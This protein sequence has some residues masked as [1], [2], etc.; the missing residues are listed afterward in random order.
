MIR[1]CYTFCE[2]PSWCEVEDVI[3]PRHRKLR[4]KIS[5]TSRTLVVLAMGLG[6][7][8]VGCRL[9]GTLSDTLWL[10]VV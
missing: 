6:F 4:D 10:E 1:T 2:H 3:D 7:L 5:V 9:L 8:G